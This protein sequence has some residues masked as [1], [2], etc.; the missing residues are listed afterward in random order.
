MSIESVMPSNHL[1][2]V[3]TFSSCPQSLPAS[4][5]FPMS[6]LFTWGGQSTGVSALASVLLMT[7][8]CWFPLGLTSLI[9]VQSN[10][11]RE[12]PRT[13][14][15]PL[16]GSGVQPFYLLEDQLFK[17]GYFIKFYNNYLSLQMSKNNQR[18]YFHLCW[19][20]DFLWKYISLVAN[21]LLLKCT[22]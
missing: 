3:A 22:L 8:Q 21:S 5:A 4:G 11:S 14:R 9:S 10:E 2:P 15:S 16:R 20:L 18:I 19:G 17:G 6:W 12:S 1:I 7:I 13:L